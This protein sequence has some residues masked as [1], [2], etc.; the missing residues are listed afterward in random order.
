MAFLT[1]D[2]ALALA[3]LAMVAILA[4]EARD[5]PGPSR[6][7]TYGSDFF[8]QLLLWVLG[9]LAVVLLVRSFLPPFRDGPAVGPDLWTFA[10]ANPRI[11]ALLAL[12]GGYIWAMPQLGFR[13]ATIGYLLVAFAVLTGLRSWRTAAICAVV[14]V[15]APLL[16]HALFQYG[17]RLR[18]P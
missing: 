13:T 12:F 9:G 10:R 14:A 1:R 5:I 11:L 8:P 17:L 15:V 16:V 7:Q 18:L 4:V 2:R 3:T 6:W